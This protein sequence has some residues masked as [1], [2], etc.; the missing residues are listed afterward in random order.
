MSD[1]GP[2]LGPE[3]RL[4]PEPHSGPRPETAGARARRA[5][6]VP[7]TMRRRQRSRGGPVVMALVFIAGFVGVTFAIGYLVGRM[8]L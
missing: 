5:A 3:P 8:L 1:P 6:A 7:F 4:G 2:G